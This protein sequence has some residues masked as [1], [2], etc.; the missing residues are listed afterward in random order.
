[1]IWLTQNRSGDSGYLKTA[2]RLDEMKTF[3]NIQDTK[4]VTTG[5]DNTE[6]GTQNKDK[7]EREEHG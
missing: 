5:C 2:E 1:M 7:T 4:Q 3:G 6:T